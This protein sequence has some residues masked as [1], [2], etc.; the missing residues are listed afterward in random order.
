MPE[1]GWAILTIREKT[2]G[3]M[4]EAARKRDLTVDELVNE[5]FNPSSRTG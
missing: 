1:K 2:A 4:K 3:R 5:L